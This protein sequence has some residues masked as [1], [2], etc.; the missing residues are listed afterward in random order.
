MKQAAKI[1]NNSEAS[2]SHEN[3][4]TNGITTSVKTKGTTSIFVCNYAKGRWV[5][6][7]RPLYY[8]VGCKYIQRNWACRL[9]NRTDFSYEGYRWQSIDCKM[10]DFE[11]SDFLKRMQDK[12][13]A[14]IGDLLSREQFQSMMCTLTE[15]QESPDVEDVANKYG[16]LL[17][18]RSYLSPR[19][20][21]SLQKYQYH[22]PAF[23]VSKTV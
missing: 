12:T 23:I 22:H 21:L 15:G 17:T 7:S 1:V 19:L 4:Y 11:P 9:T 10:P 3:D 18:Q 5:A 2:S 8:P 14:F 20:G 16:F 13:V 6:D